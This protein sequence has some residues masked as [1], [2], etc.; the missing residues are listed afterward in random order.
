MVRAM[1]SN[2]SN[3][4]RRSLAVVLVALLLPIGWTSA[5]TSGADDQG[6][7]PAD[8]VTEAFS[9]FQHDPDDPSSI[10]DNS[11]RRVLVASDG[12]IWVTHDSGASWMHSDHPGVF[13]H[14]KHDPQDANSLSS[15]LRFA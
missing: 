2:R 10:A 4:I 7:G 12:V 11:T 8:P 15:R 3:R 6:A 5:A 14:L 1:N 9:S 13:K